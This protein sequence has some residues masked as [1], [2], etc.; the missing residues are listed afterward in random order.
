MYT[1]LIVLKSNRI[2]FKGDLMSTWTLC[3]KTLFQEPA[4]EQ[5]EDM[6]GP[7]EIECPYYAA[8]ND[9]LENSTLTATQKFVFVVIHVKVCST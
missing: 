5:I 3:K 1:V 4:I 2:S 6:I 9:T 8:F 7:S